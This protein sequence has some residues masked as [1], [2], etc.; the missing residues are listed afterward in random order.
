MFQVSLGLFCIQS[1]G[2]SKSSTLVRQTDNGIREAIPIPQ[3]WSF[4]RTWNG[5]GASVLDNANDTGRLNGTALD[6]G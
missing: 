1:M 2:V 4:V 6:F 5:T 3:L